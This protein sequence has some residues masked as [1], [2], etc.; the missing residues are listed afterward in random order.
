M[1]FLAGARRRRNGETT[2]FGCFLKFEV[3]GSRQAFRAACSRFYQP[4][5]AFRFRPK[6]PLQS[7]YFWDFWAFL[8]IGQGLTK[9]C[10]D[11]KSTS[12]RS[13]ILGSARRA[14]LPR[15]SA[16]SPRTRSRRATR[17]A[18]S[19]C[20]A[21]AAARPAAAGRPAAPPCLLCR[22]G[23]AG[24][25][26]LCSLPLLGFVCGGRPRGAFFARS[27]SPRVS[28]LLCAHSR[29]GAYLLGCVCVALRASENSAWHRARYS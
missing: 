29:V 11:P 2:V 27:G 6:R 5:A 23:S 25:A 20:P 14:A 13:P 17:R 4:A 24:G 22:R 26:Q 10:I 16:P 15:P 19:A 28:R 7:E 9:S 8:Q 21:P 1:N 12:T 3:A 18:A